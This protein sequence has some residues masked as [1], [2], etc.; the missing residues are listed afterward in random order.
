MSVLNIARQTVRE[1]LE[2]GSKSAILADSKSKMFCK[3]YLDS[4]K[5]DT[6]SSYQFLKF[7]TQE[8]GLNTE[9]LF[10]SISTFASVYPSQADFSKNFKSSNFD[11]LNMNLTP[12]YYNFFT[13]LGR[14]KDGVQTVVKI[15]ENLLTSLEHKSKFRIKQIFLN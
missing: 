8:H 9:K 13:Q 6:Q 4:I 14:V 3:A 2:L 15:R 1:I 11:K 10:G 7:L 12:G 5:S